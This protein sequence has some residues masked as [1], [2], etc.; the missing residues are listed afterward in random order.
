VNDFV[1]RV[2]YGGSV[3]DLFPFFGKNHNPQHIHSYILRTP[4][5]ANKS[6]LFSK[7]LRN[8]TYYSST[9]ERG[10]LYK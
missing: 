8:S 4:D 10:A 5:D 7:A 6:N 3:A 9:I 2:P 1:I